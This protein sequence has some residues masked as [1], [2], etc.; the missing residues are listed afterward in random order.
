MG[1]A[2]GLADGVLHPVGEIR[3]LIGLT[4]QDDENPIRHLFGQV[5]QQRTLRTL[6]ARDVVQT[7]DHDRGFGA[8]LQPILMQQLQ[9]PVETLA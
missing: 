7:V 8:G 4:S 1:G 5:M 9:L 3:Q 2:L 6:F